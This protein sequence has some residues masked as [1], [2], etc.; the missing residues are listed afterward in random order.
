MKVQTG[1]YT[2]RGK[3][4]ARIKIHNH[5]VW[6]VDETLSQIIVPLLKKFREKRRGVPSE[7]LDPSKEGDTEKEDKESYERAEKKW[8]EILDKIMWSMEECSAHHDRKPIPTEDSAEWKEWVDES[9]QE[10]F[11]F[12]WKDEKE[13][14]IFHKEFDE[15]GR[16]LQEGCELFGKWFTEFWC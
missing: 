1:T 9:G 13:R 7:L 3:R 14:E 8:N 10:R 6:N 5:D 16:K 2:K 11:E 15:Y 4:F 12:V